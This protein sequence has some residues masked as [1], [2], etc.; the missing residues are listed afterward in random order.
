MIAAQQELCTITKRQELCTKAKQLADASVT[1]FPADYWWAPQYDVVFLR[2]MLDY[3]NQ[4]GDRRWYALA[5]NR[6]Q[7]ALTQGRD[8]YNGFFTHGWDGNWIA[9]G[10]EEHAGNVE[11]LAW[12]AAT[13]PPA[14]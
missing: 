6:A 5:W 14:S 9:D 10:L 12:L 11:L 4:T 1:A 2:W 13:K 3:Y 8:S 7:L